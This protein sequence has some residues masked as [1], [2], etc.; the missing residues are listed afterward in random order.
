VV[1]NQIERI[2]AFQETTGLFDKVLGPILENL[3]KDQDKL[4]TDIQVKQ[5]ERSVKAVE[6][7]KKTA[8]EL[9]KIEDKRLNDLLALANAELDAQEVGKAAGEKFIADQKAIEQKSL[10]DLAA[11]ADVEL[12]NTQRRLDAEKKYTEDLKAENEKRIQNERQLISLKLQAVSDGLSAI[13]NL[14]ELFA[15]QSEK[16]Q[17]RAFNIQKG[18]S[19][20]QAG[21][22]TYESATKAFN[23]LAGIPVVGPVLG[24][25]AAAA[26]VTA[27]L[28][29]IK[30]IAS[31]KFE[32]GGDKSG[33][34]AP[35]PNL[36]ISGG[37]AASTSTN[38]VVPSSFSLFGTG[39]NANNLGFNN[40]QPQ[41]IQAYV[42]ESDVTGVQRRV[43][44]F[45]TASE[46]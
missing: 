19:I 8:E 9:K 46:L 39:A 37:G 40:N 7:A 32:G 44:R 30:K 27:G 16:Q 41:M 11:L 24:G 22:A 4:A 5:N 34:S 10:D 33:A 3:Q 18:V 29:N 38:Q 36:N 15:G 21:I 45:R 17:R 42:V 23:S 20:A 35:A 1:D 12:D 2:K 14:T 26:A 28:L 13:S 6:T 25:I 31:Q 43:E